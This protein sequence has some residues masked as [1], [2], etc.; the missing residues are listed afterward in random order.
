MSEFLTTLFV[1]GV[2]LVGFSILIFCGGCSILL[3]IREALSRSP[4]ISD[5]FYQDQQKATRMLIIAYALL[6][7]GALA[8]VA[9]FVLM[10]L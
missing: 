3:V 7:L 4:N 1:L 9:V 10:K 6:F 2:A 5:L 8:F